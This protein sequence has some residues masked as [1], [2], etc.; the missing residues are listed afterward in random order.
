MKKFVI[1]GRKVTGGTAEGEAL[2]SKQSLA[3]TGGIDP[4]TGKVVEKDF[5]VF[6]QNIKDKVLVY[7]RGKGS[8]YFSHTAHL[9]RVY[10]N[11]P[12]AMIVGEM[13]PFTALASVVLHVPVV[14]DPFDKD[15]VASIITGDWIKVDGDKGI[16]EVTRKE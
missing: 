12:A 3:F 13:N 9:C 14:G 11:V 16:I 6:G 2:V 5:D 10:G 8:T 7:P 1:F 4:F 15:P